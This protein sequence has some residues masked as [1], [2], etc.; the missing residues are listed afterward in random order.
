MLPLLDAADSVARY[1]W[2][3]ARNPPDPTGWVAASN[4]LPAPTGTGWSKTSHQACAS[5]QTMW[6]SQHGSVA[7]CQ[8]KTLD[9][10]GCGTPKTAVYESS[11]V[12]NC[13]CANSSTCTPTPSSWQDRYV[14]SGPPPP[15]WTETPGK[16]CAPNQ[17]L[18]LGQH[19]T[20]DICQAL[21]TAKID[22]AE[23]PTKA[24]IYESG[25]VKNW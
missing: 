13:Y 16:A 17:M 15:P 12:R 3:T 24:I 21:A 20:V 11:G 2:Y 10:A 6:L 1:A 22:C 9:A 14:H 7:E 23:T 4:L 8:A 5:D 18:W 25:D 19:D